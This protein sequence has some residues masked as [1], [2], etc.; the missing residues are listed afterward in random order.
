MIANTNKK[1]GL[2]DSK[3]NERRAECDHALS[4]LQRRVPVKSLCEL[5]VAQLEHIKDAVTSPVEYRRVRHAVT[6]NQRTLEAVKSLQNN[7]LPA[8]GRLMNQS[9]LS[10]RDDYEVTGTELDLLAAA[11]W[12]HPGCIGSRMTGAGFGGCT[13]SLVLQDRLDD[14]IAHVGAHYRQSTGIE[15]DFYV[16]HVGNGA[17]KI[18]GGN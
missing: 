13:V 14:F 11:A 17:G 1:R 5:Q 15:A 18:D 16:V 12:S 4:L 7:D 3:Y 2:A 8:F 9:H 6:E 10:L